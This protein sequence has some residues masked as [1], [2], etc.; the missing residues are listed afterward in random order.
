MGLKGYN[1]D[2]FGVGKM[3]QMAGIEPRGKKVMVLGSGG[4]AK[5]VTA[6]LK[7]R[8]AAGHTSCKP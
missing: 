5:T 6:L 7:D 3:L 1:T 2:Y 8:G 4:S